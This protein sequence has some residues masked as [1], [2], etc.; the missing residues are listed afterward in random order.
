MTP[1]PELSGYFTDRSGR[2]WSKMPGNGRWLK[3]HLMRQWTDP[4]GYKHV[5]LRSGARK[6]YPVHLLVAA[7]YLG[8]RPEGFV[9]AH[10]NGNPS[11]NRARNL[12]Y[13]TQKEN[14][15]HKT[16]HG[17]AVVGE[18][19]H[20]S[21]LSDVQAREVLTLALAGDLTRREIADRFGVAVVTVDHIKS[22]RIR[23]HLRCGRPVLKDDRPTIRSRLPK[24][25]SERKPIPGFSG[26]EA[27][28]IGNIFSVKTGHPNRWLPVHRLTPH[29][30]R[31]G[32]PQV[33]IRVDA[34]KMRNIPVH[35]LVALAWL[36]PRPDGYMVHHINSM[37]D[38]NRLENLE[39]VTAFRNAFHRD[40][41]NPSS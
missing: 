24:D 28:A 34:N 32:Y 5:T 8:P 30:G 20:H 25:Q 17:T 19:S 6:R 41:F 13:V 26:Y 31:D 22:G 27:D 40:N 29:L 21:K 2:I 37:R 12:K 15:A 3:P 39:Y 16:K 18:K 35:R 33:Q 1:I 4:N 9:C 7:A 36:G 10:L 23:K 11:D 38:D 14:I